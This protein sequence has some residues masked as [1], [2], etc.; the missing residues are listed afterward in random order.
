MTHKAF[1]KK[2]CMECSKQGPTFRF[3]T[4]ICDNPKSDHYQHILTQKHHICEYFE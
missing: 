4:F 2:T 1:S 3:G